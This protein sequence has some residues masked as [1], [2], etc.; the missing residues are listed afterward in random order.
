MHAHLCEHE[1]IEIKVLETYFTS[2]LSSPFRGILT[3][4]P[5]S[6]LSSRVYRRAAAV[7]VRVSSRVLTRGHALVTLPAVGG[8]R[9]EAD[10]PRTRTLKN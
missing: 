6:V 5:H 8:T 1:M 3:V 7:H 4:S 2:C 10:R 9:Q